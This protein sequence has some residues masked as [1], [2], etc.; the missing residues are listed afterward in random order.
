[1]TGSSTGRC[2]VCWANLPEGGLQCPVCG[3][4][5]GRLEP[6][7][8]CRAEALVSPSAALR[9]ACQACN[10]PRIPRLGPA[11]ARSGR[12]VPLLRD[13][14]RARKG[15]TLWRILAGTAAVV[16]A[17]E[18]LL[19][20][21]FALVA[22]LSVGFLVAAALFVGPVLAMVAVALG[23]VPLPRRSAPT[24]ARR[25]RLAVATD[26]AQ[27]S[28]GTLTAASLGEKLWD[29]GGPCGRAAHPAGRQSN[30]GADARTNRARRKHGVA[31]CWT[32]GSPR[33]RGT[34]RS[35]RGRTGTV[36]AEHRHTSPLLPIARFECSRLQA[37]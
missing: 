1:M 20:S 29:S 34:R 17:A 11:A 31:R 5:A 27:H 26:V 19:A 32:R 22:G 21:I 12:E 7:P 33:L 15:Q 4:P 30:R 28:G 3:A 13:A 14:D 25:S 8:H 18:L 36:C 2:H 24:R 10:G 9:Y 37:R 6:C 23:E 16:L 35:R